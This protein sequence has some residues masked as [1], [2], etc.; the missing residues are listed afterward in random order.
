MK[1][2]RLSPLILRITYE[3][4]F[5]VYNSKSIYFYWQTLA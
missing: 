3:I 2:T 1:I 4:Y 5:K